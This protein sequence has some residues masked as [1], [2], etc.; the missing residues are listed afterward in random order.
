MKH[1]PVAQNESSA[2]KLMW[3]YIIVNLYDG[4]CTVSL[5]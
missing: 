1:S 3:S 2:E 5:A 4:V